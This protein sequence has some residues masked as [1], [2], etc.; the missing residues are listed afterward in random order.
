MTS[1]LTRRTRIDAATDPD[2]IGADYPDTAPRPSA[3]LY[4][5][6]T[7][8]SLAAVAAGVVATIAGNR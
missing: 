8:A 4:V 2:F 5:G 7:I 1:N 6:A 3:R